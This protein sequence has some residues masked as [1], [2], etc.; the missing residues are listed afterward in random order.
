MPLVLQDIL[1][2]HSKKQSKNKDMYSTTSFACHLSAVTVS[3]ELGGLLKE[4]VGEETTV[5]RTEWIPRSKAFGRISRARSASPCPFTNRS[6][7][8]QMEPFPVYEEDEKEWEKWKACIEAVPSPY[9]GTNHCNQH[10]RRRACRT[11]THYD[12]KRHIVQRACECNSQTALKDDASDDKRASHLTSKCV[13]NAQC[14]YKVASKDAFLTLGLDSSTSLVRKLRAMGSLDIR[15]HLRRHCDFTPSTLRYR[16]DYRAATRSANQFIGKLI[17]YLQITLSTLPGQKS[18]ISITGLEGAM[19]EAMRLELFWWMAE[20]C[21][22][23]RLKGWDDK[24][25]KAAKLA[26]GYSHARKAWVDGKVDKGVEAL[27]QRIEEVVETV[28]SVLVWWSELEKQESCEMAKQIEEDAQTER[29]RSWPYSSGSSDSEDEDENA[30]FAS[31]A[32]AP[33]QPSNRS[34]NI[35]IPPRNVRLPIAPLS[36]FF[37]GINEEINTEP[38]PSFEDPLCLP[39][40]V[41]DES[42]HCIHHCDED[43]CKRLRQNRRR[44]IPPCRCD[45]EQVPDTSESAT[46]PSHRPPLNV[47]A[48]SD[49]ARDQALLKPASPDTEFK[50]YFTEALAVLRH[51]DN[52]AAAQ[53]LRNRGFMTAIE[54]DFPG[55]QFSIAFSAVDIFFGMMHL[56]FS[57][58]HHSSDTRVVTVKQLRVELDVYVWTMLR[59]WVEQNCD[60]ETLEYIMNRHGPNCI[61]TADAGAPAAVLGFWQDCVDQVV[62]VLV[63]RDEQVREEMVATSVA[64][65]LVMVALAWIIL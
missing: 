34:P 33:T 19:K 64:L 17:L 51:L 44:R 3:V 56:Y 26:A 59:D 48:L 55:Q 65:V 2:K 21:L 61:E 29:Y 24:R 53:V 42:F 37:D 18:R 52:C 8:E 6:P 5:P 50:I 4:T 13:T 7:P 16:N 10:C 35:N 11:T 23:N 40:T 14:V 58:T 57:R 28:V 45:F 38:F 62:A 36:P 9:G 60:Y 22:P 46:E 25:T 31:A 63:R 49:D 30:N 20:W 32:S 54:H 27:W 1:N 39:A 47:Q 41:P 15:S 12:K 43:I